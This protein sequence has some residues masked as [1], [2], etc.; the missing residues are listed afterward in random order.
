LK[1]RWLPGKDQEGEFEGL[2]ET[3]VR[4][5]DGISASCCK[6]SRV[7]RSAETSISRAA[8]SHTNTCSQKQG[9]VADR[10]K[11]NIGDLDTDAGLRFGWSSGAED[12][13]QCRG[14]DAP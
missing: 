8:G 13:A 5:L 12:G 11:A 9:A 14:Y 4:E 1:K 6:V 3:D 10:S 2:G 7:E